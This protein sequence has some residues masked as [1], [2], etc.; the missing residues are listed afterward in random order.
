ML[1]KKKGLLILSVLCLTAS[2]AVAEIVD[3]VRQRPAATWIAEG[4][5]MDEVY[6]LYNT[7]ARQFFC[8]ANDWNTRASVSPKGY[9]LKLVDAGDGTVEIVDSVETQSAWKSTFSTEDAGAI[10]VDN[11]TETYRF[12]TFENADG[13]YRISNIVAE[14]KYLGW[15]GNDG[16]TRLYFLE[17]TAAG[18]NWQFVNEE[19]YQAYQTAWEGMEEQFEAAAELKTYLDAAKA[20]GVDVSTWETVYLNE[21]A[22]VD[23]I[24]AATAAVQK[25]IND[26]A[27][28][29]ASVANPSDMTASIL[30]PNFDNASYD[31]W[32]GTAPNMVGSG[33]HGPANVAEHYNKTF[34]TY[35]DLN[36]MPK[37][38]YAL[39]ANAVFRG[40]WDD[41]VNHT[42]YVAFLYAS[43]DGD[44]LTAEIP[45]PWDAMNTEPMAG[46]TEWGVDATESS[47][48]VDGV[49]YYIPNDPSAGRLYFE[50]GYYLKQVFFALDSDSPVRVGVRKDK[51][52]TST[53]W[54]MFDNFR[55]TYY[56]DAAD[57]YQFWL[58][59]M[60][61]GATDYSNAAASVQYK[62][63]YLAAYD[64]Q[65]SNKQEA[66]A[67]MQA[68]QEAAEAISLNISLWNQLT[69]ARD[70]GMKYVV[71]SGYEGLNAIGDLSDYL[72][73]VD[74]TMLNGDESSRSASNDE[75]QAAIDQILHLVEAVKEEAKTALRPGGDATSYM[76]NPDFSDGTN[77]WT[78]VSN[79]GG[80][81]Q[82][83]AGTFEA[84][85]ST[86][87]DVYQEVHDLPL[88]V[89]EI[90]V[91]GY[92]RYLDGQSAINAKGS[93][94][95]DIPI[96]VYMNEAKTR[97]ANWFDYPQESGF[98]GNV[99]GA[100]Y[101]TDDAG[102]EYPDN[103]TA[104]AAAFAKGDY[105]QSAYGLV[106]N[107]GDVLRVGVKGN[108]STAEFWPCFDN[109][110]LTYRG[111]TADVVKPILEESLANA[112][113]Q[114]VG[115]TTKTARTQMDEAVAEAQKAISGDD[116]K[117]MFDALSLLTVAV[118]A[119]EEGSVLC[120]QLYAAAEDLVLVA[121]E[122]ASAKVSEAQTLAAEVIGKL[123]AS[124]LDTDDIAAY[125]EQIAKLKIQLQLPDDYQNASDASPADVTAFIQTPSFSKY[126]DGEETNSIE[127]WTAKGYKFGNSDQL[128]ALALE[129]W[130]S[131]L[132][133]YQDI[134]GLPNGIYVLKVN[135]WQRT[136][137]PTYLYAVSAGQ[138]YSKEL[139]TQEAGLPD[140]YSAPGTLIDAVSM[141]DEYT[142]MNELVVKVTDETLR[143]GILKEQTSSADWVV[144]DNFQLFYHGTGSTLTPEEGPLAVDDIAVSTVQKVEHFTLDGRKTSAQRHGL[145]IRKTT[146]ADGTVIV[147]KSLNK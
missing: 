15:N 4:Y 73:D 78:I 19:G 29:G 32:K 7:A 3:G 130:E 76:V 27:A 26:K 37:G 100:T 13:A 114:T 56:G 34:D 85:H 112:Q 69:D 96:Y 25:A 30:N 59:E 108:P 97:F 128:S 45:N 21:A 93:T 141:F 36:G 138:Y 42:N 6:Y 54:V 16:D 136:S 61:K 107:Q 121:S 22:T 109:F 105:T 60:K 99:S 82:S 74:D 64:A 142:Y 33:A 65:V 92:V 51:T 47:Q 11:S 43:V 66:L 77:G 122:S 147:K 102:Y 95:E 52:V 131:E 50:K 113:A 86:D 40:S 79:G 1:M 129:S 12:W 84:W 35:Q 5:Q 126:V 10:W 39:A 145:V 88:G 41:H 89:Y 68:V 120:K 49:T 90:S 111:Y 2:G 106:A 127:G 70:Q 133:I 116:G 71:D 58:D 53:D 115:M 17:P 8:G 57:A 124:E 91:Q 123:E 9:K 137:N 48:D 23:E 75:L 20:E 18:I 103:T 110:R 38:V 46:A 139:I 140:G 72:A 118:N 104:A 83:T 98:Y 117:A 125:Q 94:P 143:I 134:V 87:F 135:A 55:L 24:T 80:N 119:V 31:G 146:L 44:T 101:L 67:A 144:M 62:E 14:G 132:S 28:G 63:A 81:V